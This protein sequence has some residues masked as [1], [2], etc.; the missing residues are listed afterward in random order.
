MDSV[1]VHFGGEIIIILSLYAINDDLV[2]QVKN[3]FVENMRKVLGSHL[4][5]IY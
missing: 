1:L 3:K 4:Q 2:F 5:G